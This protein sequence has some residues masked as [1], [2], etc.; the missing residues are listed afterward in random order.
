LQ[1]YRDDLKLSS[2]LRFVENPGTISQHNLNEANLNA[3]YCQA[4]RS[5]H[6]KLENGILIYCKPIAGS[7]S[8][9]RLQLVLTSFWN[10]IFV[11]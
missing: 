10:I 5:L 2:V 8:Y 6:I 3:N 9:A 4:L 11:A 7:E 1:V